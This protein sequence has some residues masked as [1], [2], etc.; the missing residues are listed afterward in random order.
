MH[1]QDSRGARNNSVL[2]R[3]LRGM[4]RI[5]KPTTEQE[6][7]AE[8]LGPR[9]IAE[10]VQRGRLVKK[11]RPIEMQ[12]FDAKRDTVVLAYDPRHHPSPVVGLAPGYRPGEVIVT[13]DGDEVLRIP[14]AAGI[15]LSSI[16]LI[17][18]DI[19]S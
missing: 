1:D 12:E 5:R 13:L 8:A 15:D 9:S 11:G 14:D 3:V 6:S 17:E 2:S 18:A 19:G 7:H 10:V 16:S 4:S